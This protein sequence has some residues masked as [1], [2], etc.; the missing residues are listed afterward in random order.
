M[1]ALSSAARALA[2]IEG[3]DHVRPDDIQTLA[4]PV[5]AHRLLLE[6]PHHDGAGQLLGELLGKVAVP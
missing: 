2:L 1:L 3:R 4:E 6:A 5:L